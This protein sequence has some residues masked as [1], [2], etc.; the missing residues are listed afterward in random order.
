MRIISFDEKRKALRLRV[1][2]IDDLWTL[3]NVLREGDLVISRTLRDVKID[4]EGKRRKPMT[5]LLEVKNVY[6][7]PFASRLR[8]HGIIKDAPEGYGLRG[9]HHT[10]NIDVGS[11]LEIIKDSWTD[12]ILRRLKKSS[13][14]WVRALLIA[15]DFDEASVAMMHKQG[16][17]YIL[18]FSLPGVNER[19]EYSI[20]RIIDR[21]VENL[22][23]VYE[24]ESPEFVIVGS[25]SILRE[26][27]AKKLKDELGKN[28][29]II[30]D[31]VSTGGRAGIEELVRRDSV[32]GLLKE[33]AAIEAEET[34]SE[35][36]RLLSS[37]PERVAMGLEDVEFAV[38]SNA[39]ERILVL[40]DMLMGE[41]GDKVDLLIN[42][43]ENRGAKVRIVPTESP[44]A[45][46]LKPLGGII[47]ILRY[48]LPLEI[49]RNKELNE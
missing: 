31:S 9:S 22:K 21:I 11:E 40:E 18:D 42:E 24:R 5:I 10:L 19:D 23:R 1:E 38:S 15:A 17:R 36:M 43:A 30:T 28:A 35:F 16:L 46:K 39:A 6:F 33:A 32:K 7:Q 44:A 8:V 47:A 2:D 20:S 27:L 45:I 26:L 25:P 34:L 29:R 3:K 14:R 4:G 37:K 13:S 48:S 49:R 41:Y 12:S